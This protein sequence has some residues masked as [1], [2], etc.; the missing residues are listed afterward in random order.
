[1]K[2][3][4]MNRTFHAMKNEGK[5][6]I[7]EK[8]NMAHLLQTNNDTS[9]SNQWKSNQGRHNRF[10]RCVLITLSVYIF[11]A[12]IRPMH[13]TELARAIVV[14]HSGVRIYTDFVVSSEFQYPIMFLTLVGYDHDHDYD[15]I[16]PNPK[17]DNDERNNITKKGLGPPLAKF[18]FLGNGTQ[19]GNGNIN[20]NG[21]GTDLF[22]PPPLTRKDASIKRDGEWNVVYT[23]DIEV[24]PWAADLSFILSWRLEYSSYTD[25]I[26][27]YPTKTHSFQGA[28][29]DSFILPTLENGERHQPNDTMVHRPWLRKRS[30]RSEWMY[31]PSQDD[32]GNG[33]DK[34]ISTSCK[35]WNEK[36]LYSVLIVGDS[37]PNYMCNHLAQYNPTRSRCVS[38]K[39]NFTNG[40]GTELLDF[41]K[42]YLSVL[43]EAQEDVIIFNTQGLWETAYGRFAGFQTRL[44]TVL[45]SIPSKQKRRKY[46]FLTTTAVHPNNYKPGIFLDNNK[47]AMTQPRVQAINSVCRER[48]NTS[49]NKDIFMIDVEALSLLRE[50][51]PMVQGDMRH[52]GNRTNELLLSHL[53]CEVDKR[54][55]S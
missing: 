29:S 19:T 44:D 1:L 55:V 31:Y 22:L 17:D 49:S 5:T 51:D 3:R 30:G 23:I 46:F 12:L 11:A 15:Y 28:P 18:V 40:T 48:I 25:A 20:W 36:R 54:L 27:D 43:N 32:I 35:P 34:E 47:W 37:Q 24:P 8:K 52:Y 26:A 10:A 4:G 14:H 50:D 41:S 6:A 21:R 7:E 9:T 38:L 45:D 13:D 42:R 2:K 53:L 39:G 16:H 33:G